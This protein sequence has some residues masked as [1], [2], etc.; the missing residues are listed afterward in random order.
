MLR[1]LFGV[2]LLVH[3]AIHLL[4]LAP[5]P[6]DPKYPFRWHSPWL[7]DDTVMKLQGALTAMIML[8]FLGYAVAAIGLWTPGLSTVWGAAAVLASVLSVALTAVLWNPQ[9]V[10]NPIIDAAIVAVVLLGW[11]R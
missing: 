8:V 6:A 10:F 7:Q 1:V 11:L 9:F 4:W 2:A 5:K 3:G